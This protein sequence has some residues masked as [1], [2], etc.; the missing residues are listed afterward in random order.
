MSETNKP[1]AELLGRAA[2]TTV[3]DLVHVAVELEVVAVRVL[4]RDV[5]V[6]AGA[7]AA[8]TAYGGSAAVGDGMPVMRPH[9]SRR[10]SLW[11]LVVW[12]APSW[13][14]RAAAHFP[15]DSLGCHFRAMRK[16]LT[17]LDDFGSWL[18]RTA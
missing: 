10:H 2:A 6:A 15:T 11:A 3:P 18:V 17:A 1:F 14:G 4:E 16:W 7:L 13:R 9:S 5:D 12:R 8:L